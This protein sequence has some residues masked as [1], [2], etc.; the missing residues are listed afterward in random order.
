[1][2]TGTVLDP[3]C[4]MSIR[5]SDAV[6]TA[7]VDGWRRFYFCSWNCHEAF[8]DLPHVYVGWNDEGERRVGREAVSR[9]AGRSA[10]SN[11]AT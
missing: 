10:P 1:M 8:L 4:E 3:V 9:L 5:P 11:R 7:I 2:T 6:A